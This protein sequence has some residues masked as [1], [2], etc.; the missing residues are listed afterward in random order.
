MLWRC[1]LFLRVPSHLQAL[2][3]SRSLL[4]PLW[5]SSLA[6]AL[7]VLGAIALV[8]AI[9]GTTTYTYDE[10]GR[11]K[12]VTKPTG[13][14][15]TYNLDPAGNRSSVS[16]VD[17]QPPSAPGTL[18]GTAVSGTQVNL[19]WGAATDN[20]AVT[21]YR[22][23]RNGSVV[24]TPTGTSYSD[25]GLTSA[26]S[27]A[28]RVTALDAAANEG[29]SSNTIAVGTPDTIAPSVP[30]GLAGAA[31]SGSQIN[32]SWSASTDNV[33]VVGYKIYRNGTQ[34][35]TPSSTSFSDTGLSQYTNYSYT[36]AAYDAAG[37]ASAASGAVVVRT[38][39]VSAP[40]VPTGVSA[41]GAS[42]SQ[43]NVSWSASTDNV[44]VAGY[45]LYRNGVHI[46]S[47]TTAAYTDAGL[48][49]ATSYSY[50]VAAF[51]A[52]GNTSGQSAAS[53][54]TTLDVS[55]PT[56]PTG[57]SATAASGSQIN[58]AWSASSDN[59]GVAGYRIYRGGTLITSTTATSYSNT[60]LAS[61]T[62]YSYTVAAYDAAGNQ[63]AQSTA[64]SA[65][66]PDVTPPTTPTSLTATA[67]SSSQ[68]NL[69]WGASTDN[70]FAGYRIYRNG[71][72]LVQT[73][74]TATTY[75]NAGLSA[76]TTY[77]YYVTAYDG[78]GN[79][80]SASNTASATT[81]SGIAAPGIPGNIR[82]DPATG[83]GR[84]FSIL[85]DVPS[86]TVNHYTLEEVQQSPSSSTTI[87]NT[88]TSAFQSFTK[89]NAY[90]LWVYRVRACA[91]ADESYCS[92]YSGTV[93][94]QVCSTTTGCP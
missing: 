36:V 88:G 19:S 37:N 77:S 86:G 16:I 5:F 50:T 64:A 60:G 61:E 52:A 57:F 33:V 82:K 11:L 22:V 20:V 59:V 28:Y 18:S 8:P 43:I 93:M 9:A 38:L 32:L 54:G 13:L 56:T 55:A 23:Y 7:A 68:I 76:S 30:M 4:R 6:G 92:S 79:V 2:H 85:W 62:T 91:T 89:P 12:T 35:A 47:P 21:S 58:L 39:D 81:Q 65:T 80:S 94:K 90:G 15:V 41:A 44:G 84:V 66:T 51:D 78:A 67:V 29:A 83:N 26:T 69:S 75:S 10:L 31:A 49:Q 87:Y 73:T 24:G 14:Q 46:A 70:L 40:S 74:N 1:G 63:S 17:V 34:V 3:V 72:L 27:Y 45:R 25:T 42:G 71:V 48:P 53:V